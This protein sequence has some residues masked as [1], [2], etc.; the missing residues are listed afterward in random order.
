MNYGIVKPV[1]IAFF[2][3]VLLSPMMI[4]Y[5]HKLKFGAVYPGRRTRI[6]SEEI[7]DSDDGRTDHITWNRNRIVI[8]C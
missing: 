8:L 2:I 5:L 4:R 1:L 6:T 7:R 3:S